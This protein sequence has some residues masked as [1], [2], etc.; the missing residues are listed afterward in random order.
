MVSLP[1][2][3]PSLSVMK[4]KNGDFESLAISSHDTASMSRLPHTSG[5]L[6]NM[7]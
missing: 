7:Y 3:F 4:S 6:M 2:D 1:A 5:V